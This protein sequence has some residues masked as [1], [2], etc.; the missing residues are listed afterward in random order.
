MVFQ[1]QIRPFSTPPR[2]KGQRD[3][4]YFSYSQTEAPLCPP[5]TLIDLFRK[6]EKDAER[7]LRFSRTSL[8]WVWLVRFA[9]YWPTRVLE[10]VGLCCSA[11]PTAIY[12]CW[13]NRKT[14]VLLA[15]VLIFN[16]RVILFYFKDS[17]VT[18]FHNPSTIGAD[19]M[20]TWE[21]LPVLVSWPERFINP[22]WRSPEFHYLCSIL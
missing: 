4:K 8:W 12:V 3:P 10:V 18:E 1:W 20:S 9:Q 21:V 11:A 22:T 6:R 13:W 7:H 5:L 15:I 2:S 16:R 14:N 19:L 17:L